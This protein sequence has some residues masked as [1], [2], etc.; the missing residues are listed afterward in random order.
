M[1][2][3][4]YVQANE[5]MTG[6]VKI[7]PARDS[8]ETRLTQLSAPACVPL[9]FECHFAAEVKD[10]ARIE[11]GDG[12]VHALAAEIGCSSSQQVAGIKAA[13]NR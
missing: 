8:V 2:E 9:T 12:E 10:G 4:V 6:L 13:L 11:R 3:I 7:G 1:P 5:A